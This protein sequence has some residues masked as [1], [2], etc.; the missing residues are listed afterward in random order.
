MA[1]FCGKCGS[2]LD[3]T[4]GTCPKCDKELKVDTSQFNNKIQNAKKDKKKAKS[5]ARSKGQKKRCFLLKLLFIFL[6]LVIL[7]AGV[8]GALVYYDLVD[9]PLINNFFIST[10]L[11]QE[12]LQ[13]SNQIDSDD[14]DETLSS[15]YEVTP[16]D[17]DEYF[18]NNS[19]IISELYIIDSKEVHTEAETYKNLTD[20]GFGENPITTEYAMDGEYHNPIEISNTSS[21][22]HPVYETYY[23]STNG[24]IWMLYEINGVLIANPLSYNDQSGLNVLVMISE[25]NTITSYD[26]TTNK[27][28]E[29]I[30]NKS[31]LIVKTVNRIDAETLD[32]LTFG[33]IDAL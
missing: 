10:G 18:Q 32:N 29:T 19:T 22:K 26:S 4:T 28:Y 20:R 30:L 27:F 16:P 24:D 33:E 23:I 8:L 7:A 11:K 2:K 1:K 15:S 12:E 6:L 17:A 3:D 21:S 5:S 9:I 13:P 25:S 14:Y 31:E